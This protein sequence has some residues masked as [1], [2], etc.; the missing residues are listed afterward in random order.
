MKYYLVFVEYDVEPALIGPYDYPSE[1]DE[2]ARS[3]RRT[4]GKEHGYYPLT[5]TGDARLEIGSYSGAFFE[6]VDE[7]NGL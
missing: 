2:A 4:E 3:I 1:R 7:E 5:V 6:D